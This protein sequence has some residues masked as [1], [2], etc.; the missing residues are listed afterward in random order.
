M[1]PLQG[2]DYFTDL[3]VEL[4]QDIASHLPLF[5]KLKLRTVFNRQQEDLVVKLLGNGIRNLYVSPTTASLERFANICE[6]SFFQEHVTKICFVP[7]A[8]VPD[9]LEARLSFRKYRDTFPQFSNAE[10]MISF[11]MYNSVIDE[12]QAE[13]DTEGQ[14]QADVINILQAGIAR[15]TKV[16]TVSVRFMILED[17]MNGCELHHGQYYHEMN[18]YKSLTPTKAMCHIKTA[19]MESSAKLLKIAQVEA[20]VKAVRNSGIAIRH[21]ALSRYNGGQYHD[22][23]LPGV[24]TEFGDLTLETITSVLNGVTELTVSRGSF[25]GSLATTAICIA[26]T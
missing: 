1:P 2:H 18:G 22:A 13:S 19:A 6:S 4:L 24:F 26:L 15:M 10:A 11:A 8:I 21:F 23:Q 3:P 25:T 20:F 9:R 7:Y 5:H 16:D 14:S 12:H 17:G